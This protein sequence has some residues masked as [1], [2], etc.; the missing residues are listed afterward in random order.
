MVPVNATTYGGYVNVSRQNIDWSQPAIMDLVINDL[1]SAYAQETETAFC[2]RPGRRGDR[3]ADAAGEPAR[4]RT[5]PARSGR[6]VGRCTP[7]SRVPGRTII[8]VTGP[9]CSGL[10]GPLFPPVNPT[11]A[12]GSRVLRRVFGSGPQGTISGIS[13]VVSYG[14]AAGTMLVANTAAAEVYEDRIGGCRSS[15]RRSSGCRSRTPATSP[16]W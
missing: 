10:V 15:S 9:T 13:V 7:A 12:Q 3:G 11:N 1:A 5:S 2:R 16:T 14:F 4:P 8:A 6:A